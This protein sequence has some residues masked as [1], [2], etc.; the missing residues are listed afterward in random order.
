LLAAAENLDGWDRVAQEVRREAAACDVDAATAYLLA[1]TLIGTW[2]IDAD[3]LEGYLEKA[4]R[5]AKLFT[6]W[7]DPNGAYEQRILRLARACLS[8]SVAETISGVVEANGPAARAT[9]LATK[10]LQLTLPGVPD[11]YQGT[12]LAVLALVDP[13]NRRAVDF[14]RGQTLLDQLHASGLTEDLAGVLDAEKLWLTSQVLRLRR[15]RP[16]LFQGGSS[17]APVTSRSPHLLGFLRNN[18]VATLVTRWPALLSRSGWG[19]ATVDLPPGQ[20][21]DV[22]TGNQFLVGDARLR[23]ADLLSDLPVALLLEERP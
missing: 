9:T 13:D 2:P 5:E 21:I 22:L 14:V 4:A 20:W 23:C 10:L 6:T 1:Q 18:Q 3:R 11:V 17:F 12:E 8:G 7:N 19:D 15:D 16:K